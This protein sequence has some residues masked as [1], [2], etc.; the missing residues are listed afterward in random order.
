MFWRA[1][2]LLL[3]GLAGPVF[4]AQIEYLYINANE[5]TASGGHTALKFG[6]EVFHFQH[7]PPGLLR[8]K[9]DDFAQFRLQYGE[10]ENRSIRLHR[11]EVADDTQ[12]LLRERFNRILLVEEE[13]YGR[14]EG[15]EQDGL[16][17]KALL[18]Q[19]GADCGGD[20]PQW[21]ELKGLGLFLAE[22]RQL[23][24]PAVP[25]GTLVRLAW[26]LQ[27]RYGEGFL[28]AQADGL[29]RRLKSVRPE[30][31]DARSI[32][33][34]AGQFQPVRRSFAEQYL[35]YLSAWAA[36]KVL[37][38][39][40]PVRQGL[41]AQPE[42]AEFR[43]DSAARQGLAGYRARLEEQLLELARPER[44]DWGFPLLSGMARLLALDVSIATGRLAFLNP[45]TDQ[46]E[47]DAP[48]ESGFQAYARHRDRF[49]QAKAALAAGTV[50]EWSYARLEQS[51]RLL[52]EAGT[53][54]REARPPRWPT[55]ASLPAAKLAPTP[56]D[57][58]P[59]QLLAS[60]RQLDAYRSA[61]EAKL[62][63]LYAYD[64]LGRNCVSEIFRVLDGAMRSLAPAGAEAEAVRRLGGPIPDPGTVFIPFLAFDAVG[65]QWR[66][67][68]S[69]ELPSHRLRR[70]REAQS[71]QGPLWVGLRESNVFSSEIYRWHGNDAAFVFFTDDTVWGRPLA[72]AFNLAAGMAQAGF[73][74]FK[75]PWDGGENLWLGL[76]GS[77][78]SLPELAFFNIR[79]GSFPGLAAPP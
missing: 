59:A 11:V 12:A 30:D 62:T 6:D 5:G 68:A 78:V 21:L 18:R 36:I 14:R 76:K 74:L 46:D 65:R 77:L 67:V 8:I 45:P 43:L 44:T 1:V 70:L 19:A 47:A 39:G 37:A 29:L 42:G 15:L 22:G 28:R 2:C 35:G 66:V 7:V 49:A 71:G 48:E 40:L 25:D 4:A 20:C 57:L 73:G 16:L 27:A 33:L 52:L 23:Q 34:A 31:Y 26:R 61:Y 3:W 38:W 60:L 10:R 56:L 55:L 64:L 13:Q 69:E 72:G 32:P 9:R 75:L 79:K 17:L 63:G 51:A 41:L 58:P 24:P 53:A 54:L 50:D